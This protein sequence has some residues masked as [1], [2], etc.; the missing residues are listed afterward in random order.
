VKE[1]EKK[2]TSTAARQNQWTYLRSWGLVIGLLAA[3]SAVVFNA[4][5]TMGSGSLPFWFQPRTQFE[6]FCSLLLLVP[7][8]WILFF[9]SLP[10]A[11]YILKDAFSV[12]PEKISA[13]FKNRAINIS[14]LGDLSIFILKIL[15]SCFVVAFSFFVFVV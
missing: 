5:Y 4:G 11:L 15:L 7:S 1:F 3:F 10:F 14:A 12:F 8:G 6:W 9:G 13:V 2:L